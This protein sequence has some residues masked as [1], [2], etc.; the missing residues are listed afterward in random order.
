MRTGRSR[1]RS[2]SRH[3]LRPPLQRPRIPGRRTLADREHHEHHPVR[4]GLPEP[5]QRR[6]AQP[7]SY[8]F[9]LGWFRRIDLTTPALPASTIPPVASCAASPATTPAASLNAAWRRTFIDPLGQSWTP[10]ASMRGDVALAS[11]DT[12]GQFNQYLP[13]FIDTSGEMVGAVHARRRRDLP[14][15]LRGQFQLRRARRSSRSR[16]S[17]CGRTKPRS[18]SCRTRMRKASSTTTPLFSRWTSSPGM[19]GSRAAPAP[20]SAPSTRS[21]D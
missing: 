6:P 16:S 14:L 9:P 7:G 3:R 12:T 1:F 13:N 18:A 21:A 2:R 15:S 20:M 10:F 5:G 19:T 17:S 4:D 8:Q 11:L